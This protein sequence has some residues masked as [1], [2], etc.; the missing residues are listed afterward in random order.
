MKKKFDKFSVPLGLLD[1]GNPVCYTITMV[2]IIKNT[3]GIMDRPFNVILLIGVVIS[4]F[5]G[6]VIPTGKVRPA[7]KRNIGIAAAK[8]DVVAFIDDDAYP[9]AHWLENAVKYFG[10]PSVGGVGGPGVTPPGDGFLARA[11][12]RVYENFFVSGNYRYRYLG[13]R[14]RLDVDD[15]PSCNLLVRTDIL[16]KIGGYR[17]DFWPGEDV[18]FCYRKMGGEYEC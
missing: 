13:G 17:T 2:T 1:Y 12:G 6:L 15:Y 11:G 10:E 5:F 8:G 4:I 18:Y 9:E 14:V 16:R 7:E 3:Y